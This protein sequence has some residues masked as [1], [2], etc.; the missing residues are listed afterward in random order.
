MSNAAQLLK[1]HYG[2][3]PWYGFRPGLWTK[4]IDVRDFIQ[5]NVT[6]YYGADTFL[7][8]PTKRTLGIWEKL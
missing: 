5:Q 1:T 8:G 6:P 7:S 4:E 2:S 3:E